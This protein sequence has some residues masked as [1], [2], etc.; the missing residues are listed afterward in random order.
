MQL[1][2]VEESVGNDV[3]KDYF[4][5]STAYELESS[6]GAKDVISIVTDTEGDHV[7][8]TIE[9]VSFNNNEEMSNVAF[10]MD[11]DIKADDIKTVVKSGMRQEGLELVYPYPSSDG[12]II[13]MPADVSNVA[14]KKNLGN[15]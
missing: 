3:Q 10:E 8:V 2:T 15:R 9:D 14:A 11:E 4:M 12:V 6:S 7:S 1:N 13:D 5:R